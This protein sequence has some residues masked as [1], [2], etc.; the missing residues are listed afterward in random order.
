MDTS[1]QLAVAF[2]QYANFHVNRNPDACTNPNQITP[3]THA[4]PGLKS[5]GSHAL[6][7]TKG[8]Q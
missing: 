4:K 2:T 3:P 8:A 5:T 6:V 1:L 7:V